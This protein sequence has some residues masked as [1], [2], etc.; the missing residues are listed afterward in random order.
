MALTS[1]IFLPLHPRTQQTLKER[2]LPHANCSHTLRGVRAQLKTSRKASARYTPSVFPLYEYATNT[3]HFEARVERTFSSEAAGSAR[4]FH[5]ASQGCSD[6][7]VAVLWGPRA[8]RPFMRFICVHHGKTLAGGSR[9]GEV[10]C[11]ALSAAYEADEAR[12]SGYATFA[13]TNNTSK[14][15]ARGWC[16]L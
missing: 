3:A 11:C 16:D 10:K 14:P 4:R 8:S 15:V 9:V 2:G 13:F 1:Q 7:A 6:A 5:C 12:T